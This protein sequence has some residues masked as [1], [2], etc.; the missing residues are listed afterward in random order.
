[1]GGDLQGVAI[2]DLT[3]IDTIGFTPGLATGLGNTM[4]QLPSR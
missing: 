2:V 3:G 1:M 4:W